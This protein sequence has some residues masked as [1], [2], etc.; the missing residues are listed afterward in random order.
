MLLK[1]EIYNDDDDDDY[2]LIAGHDD[3]RRR[4]IYDLINVKMIIYF[5]SLSVRERTAGMV[6]EGASCGAT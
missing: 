1:P 6:S 4:R 5:R 3:G 2:S